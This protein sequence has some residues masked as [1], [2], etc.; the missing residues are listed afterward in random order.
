MDSAVQQPIHK[1]HASSIHGTP[2]SS[3]FSIDHRFS[4]CRFE[5]ILP[6]A[7]HSKRQ[8]RGRSKG[9]IYTWA[10]YALLPLVLQLM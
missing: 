6:A 9:W 8:T 2:H 3:Q 7:I 1:L 5:R 10:A 4:W